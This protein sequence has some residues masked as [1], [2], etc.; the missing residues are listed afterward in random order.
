[1]AKAALAARAIE[2]EPIDRLEDKVKLLVGVVDRLRAE[3]AQ[4]KQENARLRAESTQAKD[5]NT[6]LR[7]ETAR[8]KEENA[9]LRTEGARAAEENT[10]L[11][12]E[13]EGMR[14]RLSD[15]EG[16]GAE[17][18]ALREEREQIRGRVADMLQ[19]IEAL[20]L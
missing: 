3:S 18:T 19:Q 9:R 11:R 8:D 13:L 1:M 17:L 12:A 5:E 10:R 6:K 16:T 4:E 7:A 14:G 2:L 15:A 20:N